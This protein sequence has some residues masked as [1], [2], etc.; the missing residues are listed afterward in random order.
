MAGGAANLKPPGRYPAAGNH[1][2]VAD[3]GFQAEG[4][5]APARE[6]PEIPAPDV[7]LP[8]ERLS[9]EDSVQMADQQDALALAAF[10][11]CDQVAGAVH[12]GRHLRP[13]GREADLPQLGRVELPDLADARDVVRCA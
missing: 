3:G 7:S 9:L 4:G 1:R 12:L 2:A 10:A 13:T 11:L 6:L 5:G 8:R